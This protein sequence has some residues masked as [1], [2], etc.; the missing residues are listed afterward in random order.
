MPS[1]PPG[2]SASSSSATLASG[3]SDSLAQTMFDFLVTD[4]ESVQE[5]Q[6]LLM[7]Q[8]RNTM[9]VSAVGP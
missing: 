1:S 6:Q 2:S 9:P 7:W 5:T 8:D 3:H 4:Q